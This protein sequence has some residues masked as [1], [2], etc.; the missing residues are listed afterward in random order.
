MNTHT[1][2]V[3]DDYTS[4]RAN[5]HVAYGSNKIVLEDRQRT[6]IASRYPQNDISLISDPKQD[7][8]R[9]VYRSGYELF[10]EQMPKINPEDAIELLTEKSR[11]TM[12]NIANQ[13]V[14][15]GWL[16]ERKQA[17][18][19][20]ARTI[21]GIESPQLTEYGYKEG[22][23]ILV[24]HWG[25]GFSS[26]VHGH[27]SGYM[28]EEILEGKILVH[29]YRM[30]NSQSDLVRLVSTSV[31]E[32]GTFVSQ[33]APPLNYA[34][35]RSVLIH[36]FQAITPA[37]SLHYLPEHT[38]DGKDNRFTP[39]YFEDI[40][41]IGM[42]DVEQISTQDAFNAFNGSVILVRSSNVP[43]YGD[44][45]IVITG[46]PVVKLHG[47]RPQDTAISA[48][49]IKGLLDA[50]RHDRGLVLLKLKPHMAKEFYE[51]HD[52]RVSGNEVIMPQ[53]TSISL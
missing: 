33:Y 6:L 29:T 20:F 45:Y 47:I 41:L 28:H 1:Q 48:P 16:R 19:E 40:F 25:K 37:H 32:K 31:V 21:V 3:H 4:R 8:N 43:E 51:F 10:F 39:E 24:A 5:Y 11:Q 27:S 18:G 14:E 50:Y 42:S 49:H 46:R 36:N 35:K 13:I 53:P 26:P 17:P 44:H 2:I 22:A 23:E 30:V 38:R 12:V 34:N 52:I 15:D 7:P 9:R